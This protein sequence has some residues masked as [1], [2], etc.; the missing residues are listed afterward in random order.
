L[1]VNSRVQETVGADAWLTSSRTRRHHVHRP[2][3]NKTIFP[4]PPPPLPVPKIVST[5]FVSIINFAAVFF[6]LFFSPF[7]VVFILPFWRNRI[8]KLLM[9]FCVLLALFHT[10]ST[11]AVGTE[12]ALCDSSCCC[13]C[14][15]IVLLLL[16]LLLMLQEEER[17]R[18]GGNNRNSYVHKRINNTH[19]VLDINSPDQTQ[20]STALARSLNGTC[21]SQI[22]VF[23][24]SL[25]VVVVRRG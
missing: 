17:N 18:M 3:K 10:R 2:L 8:P 22:F 14:M 1:F 13:C 25:V 16:L 11:H 19:N 5:V 23:Y 20:R 12:R 6:S 24:F 9:V 4:P 21:A 15:N 7:F